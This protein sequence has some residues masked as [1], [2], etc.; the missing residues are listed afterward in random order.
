VERWVKRSLR[1][2]TVGGSNPSRVKL[3]K[4]RKLDIRYFPVGVHHL[5]SRATM[6][7]RCK[8]KMTGRTI[9]FICG[10]VLRCAGML[11]LGES[12]DQYSRSDNHC[13]TWI[14]IANK[15]R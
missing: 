4:D 1:V 10:M 5:R 9:V 2:R 15:R 6:Q 14:Q 11:K 3:I 13:R 7:P 8:L 12:L